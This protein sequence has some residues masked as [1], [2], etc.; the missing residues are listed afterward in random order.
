[1]A[2]LFRFPKIKISI[3][4]VCLVTANVAVGGPHCSNLFLIYIID[5]TNG[6]FSDAKSFSDDTNLF[7]GILNSSNSTIEFLDDLTII[8]S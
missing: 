4:F 5:L 6:L 8:N 2:P 1:M 7:L 3:K